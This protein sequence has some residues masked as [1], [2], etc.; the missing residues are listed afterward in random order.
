MNVKA[1]LFRPTDHLIIGQGILSV[2]IH[3]SYAIKVDWNGVRNNEYKSY[4][5]SMHITDSLSRVSLTGYFDSFSGII[6]CAYRS[7]CIDTI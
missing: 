6:L 7:E 4:E 2:G 5:S 3:Y 1:I